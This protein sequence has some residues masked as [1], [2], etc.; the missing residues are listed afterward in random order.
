MSP[1]P[2]NTE[3]AHSVVSQG[4][5]R[6]IHVCISSPSEYETGAPRHSIGNSTL[7]IAHNSTRATWPESIRFRRIIQFQPHASYLRLGRPWGLRRSQELHR[8]LYAFLLLSRHLCRSRR[9]ESESA[10]HFVRVVGIYLG[11]GYLAT[12][13]QLQQPRA[14]PANQLF[15]ENGWTPK[16][17]SAPK[18]S[19]ELLRR[20]DDP[21]LCGYLE[22]DAGSFYPFLDI[23]LILRAFE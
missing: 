22:G 4:I 6:A 19:L 13:L 21:G 5:H 15:P 9:L 10:M 14:T 18:S 12:G 23:Y 3:Y 7:P 17:T 16:P 11:L 1:G 2:S 8:V 20:Q